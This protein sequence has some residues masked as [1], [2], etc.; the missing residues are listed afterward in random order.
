M[1]D[2]A[3]LLSLAWGWILPLIPFLLWC[4]WWLWCVDW[5]RAWPILA[6]GGWVVAVLFILLSGLAWSALF[7]HRPNFFWQVVASG[8]LAAAALFCGWLQGL[9]GWTPAPVEFDPPVAHHDGHG[10]G[11][12]HGHDHHH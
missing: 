12:G 9:L 6:K 2:S 7:P 8:L 4:A 11:H 3:S 5:P 1:P 10:H